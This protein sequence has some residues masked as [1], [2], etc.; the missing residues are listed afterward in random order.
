MN[1]RSSIWDNEFCNAHLCRLEKEPFL[2]LT[3]TGDEKWIVYNNIKCQRQ[4]V[5]C[6]DTPA[7]QPK[8]GLHPRKIMLSVWWDMDGV[9]HY[10]LLPA[11]KTIMKE[12]YCQQMARLK[13]SA[14]EES[15]T[16]QQKWCHFSSWECQASYS[17][18]NTP[19]TEAVW[20]GSYDT[21]AIFS[22]PGTIRLSSFPQS[23]RTH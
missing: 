19:K 6:N 17:T 15:S 13:P 21:S 14:E 5:S 1:Y 20:M 9:I 23:P 7:P 4:W 18:R 11:K 16:G 8:E 2:N 10:E 12:L 3:V 22:W